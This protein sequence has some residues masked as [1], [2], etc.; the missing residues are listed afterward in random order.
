MI[1]TNKPRRII[2]GAFSFLRVRTSNILDVIT[3]LVPVIPLRL[4]S[5]CP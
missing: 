4:V 2:G 3:G 1:D 5:M